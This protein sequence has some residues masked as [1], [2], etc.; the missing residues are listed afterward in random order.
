MTL[1]VNKSTKRSA[2]PVDTALR[3]TDLGLDQA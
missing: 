2:D 3:A 1:C